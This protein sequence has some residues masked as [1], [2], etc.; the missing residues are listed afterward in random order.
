MKTS[1]EGSGLAIE[2]STELHSN[3]DTFEC[4]SKC[5]TF[6]DKGTAGSVGARLTYEIFVVLVEIS[7]MILYIAPGQC[8]KDTWHAMHFLHSITLNV[9][10]VNFLRSNRDCNNVCQKASEN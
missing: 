2:F 10:D 9:D 7:D 4:N 6:L 5:V 1:K 8:G 3:L